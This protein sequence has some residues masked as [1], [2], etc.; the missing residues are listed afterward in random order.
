MRHARLFFALL[1]CFASPTGAA[2]EKPFLTLASTTSTNDSGLF[3]AILP[4]FEADTGIQ[5]RVVA[6][7]C[8]QEGRYFP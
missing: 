6:V 7:G 2:E 3:S 8:G 4:K 1:L 5:V